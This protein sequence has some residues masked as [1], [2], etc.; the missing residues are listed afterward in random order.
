MY[1]GRTVWREVDD[2]A[3]QDRRT[4]GPNCTGARP[5]CR[6]DVPKDT[7]A[8]FR[9]NERAARSMSIHHLPLRAVPLLGPAEMAIDCFDRAQ[10]CVRE[11]QEHRRQGRSLLAVHKYLD[12]RRLRRLGRYWQDRCA[13]IA[14]AKGSC[15]A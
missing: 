5:Q 7:P 2:T 4:E 3:E 1:P 8:T 15:S 13:V 12:V 10:R 9:V 6:L 14:Q 11:A